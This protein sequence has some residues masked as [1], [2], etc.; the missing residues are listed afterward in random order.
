MHFKHVVDGVWLDPS[1]L[2]SVKNEWFPVQTFIII[3]ENLQ[4]S[5]YILSRIEQSFINI[6]AES[7]CAAAAVGVF[8]AASR[9]GAFGKQI[10]DGLGQFGR[11]M[12]V[13]VFCPD[14]I[15][16]VEDVFILEGCAGPYPGDLRGQGAFK[17]VVAQDQ[18]EEPAADVLFDCFDMIVAGVP[19]R[20]ARLG[21]RDVAGD[22]T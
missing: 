13:A 14:Q 4:S 22:G 7:G 2:S 11:I 21:G 15:R 18:I 20:F 3:N 8:T 12:M 5:L 1:P 19:V 6:L 9:A 16:H 10:H 17:V